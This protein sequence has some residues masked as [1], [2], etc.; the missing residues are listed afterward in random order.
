MGGVCARVC[1]RVHVRACVCVRVCVMRGEG[2]R[3]MKSI[4]WTFA[5]QM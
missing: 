2:V 5:M 3:F 4:I 1:V